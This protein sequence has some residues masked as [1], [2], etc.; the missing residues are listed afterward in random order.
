MQRAEW[1]KPGD[2]D[3]LWPMLVQHCPATVSRLCH[4]DGARQVRYPT[5][6]DAGATFAEKGLGV[7]IYD[8]RP[9]LDGGFSF[10][11]DAPSA[12]TAPFGSHF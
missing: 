9:A 2:A 5:F 7:V 1:G 3:G 4:L 12:M 6:M 8:D 11:H 10:L